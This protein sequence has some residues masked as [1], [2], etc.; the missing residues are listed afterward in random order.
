MEKQLSP[1][2]IADLIAYLRQTLGPLPPSAVVLPI[3]SP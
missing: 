1:Q 3:G 2:Q